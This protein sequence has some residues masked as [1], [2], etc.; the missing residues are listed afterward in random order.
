MS[1]KQ[2]R[3]CSFILGLISVLLNM[4]GGFFLLLS[5]ILLSISIFLHITKARC[6]T[7]NR[8][9]PFGA[10]FSIEYCPYCGASLE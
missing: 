6:L 5:C 4:F 9:I 10:P 1:S 8:H 3:V 2:W 7:C